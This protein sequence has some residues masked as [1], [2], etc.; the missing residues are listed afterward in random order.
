MVNT[1]RTIAVVPEL[2][3]HLQKE[4]E[5]FKN[6]RHFRPTASPE[7]LPLIEALVRHWQNGSYLNNPHELHFEGA[8]QEAAPEVDAKVEVATDVTPFEVIIK[9]FSVSDKNVW[10]NLVMACEER[11]YGLLS[12]FTY[13]KELGEP[14]YTAGE[15]PADAVYQDDKRSEIRMR[16]SDENMSH[17]Q[18][19][20]TKYL[21]I[22]ELI[23]K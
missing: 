12:Q 10:Q 13:S 5:H 22:K 4:K 15:I 20:S 8:L 3:K 23:N 11:V 16:E 2:A 9:G 1:G 7:A 19:I 18:V 17:C 6:H 14:R 21:K